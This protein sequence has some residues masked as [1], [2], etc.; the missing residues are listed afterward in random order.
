MWLSILPLLINAGS[1]L[2]TKLV[3]NMIIFSSLQADH[4]PSMEFNSPDNVT[5][6]S[7]S[8]SF[9]SFFSASFSFSASSSSSSSFLVFL[10]PVRSREQSISSITMIDLPF[11]SSNSF[12]SSELSFTVKLAIADIMVDFPVPGGPNRR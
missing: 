7:F 6:L 3:V 4:N 11:V 9:F 10:C 1:S 5:L 12:F 8:A 2:S